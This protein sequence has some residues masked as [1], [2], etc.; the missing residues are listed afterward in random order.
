MNL[1]VQFFLFHKKSNFVNS[2]NSY[3]YYL[4]SS[5]HKKKMFLIFYIND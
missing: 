4:S 1:S 5:L 3:V 2:Q